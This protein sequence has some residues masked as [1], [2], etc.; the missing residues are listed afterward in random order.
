MIVVPTAPGAHYIG[1][2][3]AW[4]GAALASRWQ[5][6]RWPAEA[7]RL[8]D[9]TRPGY[10]VA[11][12][13]GALIGAWLFGSANTLRAM[14]AAPGHSIAGALAG[15]IFGVEV[16]KW[17]HDVRRS[18]GGAFVLPICVGMIV[19]RFGCLF[20][21]LSDFTYGTPTRLPW[22]VDLGDGIGRHPVELYEAAAMAAFLAFYLHG[23]IRHAR[24]AAAH[25]FHAMII[26][27]AGQRFAWEFLKPYPPVIGPLNIFHLLMMGLIAYGILWWRRGDTD[28]TRPP[29]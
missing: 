1:D 25:G 22:A 3:L 6:H 10:F 28:E 12:G 5:Y 26:I 13:L 21:G 27:Y 7:R 29:G 17:R 20:A 8:A 19:G 2:A 16:W 23:R 14:I 15:G 4:T 18:T 9:T 11:L 24:W